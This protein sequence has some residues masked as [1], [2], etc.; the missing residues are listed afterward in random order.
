MKVLAID[1]SNLV[2]GI[3]VM[4]EG[5]VLGEYITNLKKNHSIRVMPAIEQ[6][7][8]ET[9]VKPAELDR[10]VVAKGPGS[11]TGVRIGVTIAKTLA[12]T[13]KKELVGVSSLEVLAQS[14]KY[15]NGFTVPLFD[16][17]RTQ[18]FTGLYGQADSGEFKNRWEDRI[19]L[20]KDWLEKLQTTDK[21]TLFVGNDL[22]LHQETI[23]EVLGSQAVFGEVCD[24]NPRPSELGRIGMQ[25][26]ADDIHSFTP[27][28]L[29]LAE[30]EV[31]WLKSQG[32]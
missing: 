6:L 9:G 11:Y 18:V 24:H 2:M 28:Y 7:M 15:F 32:K 21:K 22:S 17:R 30:A 27:S 13:L 14:G 26:E 10:I 19:I 8:K 16:A 3:A 23:S 12:W 25:R 5:K 29:Q 1:T 31:N 4:D 20:L